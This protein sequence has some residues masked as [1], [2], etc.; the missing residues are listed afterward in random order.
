MITIRLA[1][2]ARSCGFTEKQA[3]KAMGGLIK[4]GR[5]WAGVVHW[6]DRDTL[7][8]EVEPIELAKMAAEWRPKGD[9]A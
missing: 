6:V 2:V 7:G 8:I 1:D 3:R 5:P 9:G 4:P